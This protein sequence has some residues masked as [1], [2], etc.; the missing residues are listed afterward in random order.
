MPKI[1]VIK[2]SH[3]YSIKYILIDSDENEIGELRNTE[4]TQL[5]KNQTNKMKK[6]IELSQSR[7]KQ[8]EQ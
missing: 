7:L 2:N 6:T 5:N 8:M 1:T 3:K 4:G